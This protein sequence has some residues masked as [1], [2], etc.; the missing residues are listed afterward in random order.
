MPGTAAVLER[1]GQCPW[2]TEDGESITL[3]RHRLLQVTRSVSLLNVNK[4]RRRCSMERN[5]GVCQR[6]ERS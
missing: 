3:A 4:P 2:K 1:R 5:W 6:R